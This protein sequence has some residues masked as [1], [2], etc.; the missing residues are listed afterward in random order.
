MARN[1]ERRRP[2]PDELAGFAGRLLPAPV[3]RTLLG[4]ALQGLGV[5]LC[6]HRVAPRPRPTDWQHGLSMP[7]PELDALIELLLSSRPGASKGW[8]SI[9]FD[10]GY[11]DAADYLRARAP[12]FPEVEFL[13]FVCPEKAEAR[14]GFRWD[15]VEESLKAGQPQAQALL[16]APVD[17]AQEN[18]RPELKALT[19]LDDYALST[20]DELRALAELPNVTLGNHTSLHLSPAK[21]PDEVVKADFERSTAEFTRLFGAQRHFAFPF[22][23]PRAHF[24]QRHVDWLRALGDFPIWTTEA[25]PFRLEERTARAVLPRFPV[26]GSKDA[27]TLGG[28]IAARSLDFRLRGTRH[29]FPPG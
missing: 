12:R 29:P 3:L 5:S 27:L 17:V 14:A 25:R 11:R 1:Q 15:L 21:S 6:L 26:D 20:V 13:F 23:T 10:D 7:A 9:T 8:L 16:D 2:S 28:W 22:G 19:A 18:A 4:Q 24:A